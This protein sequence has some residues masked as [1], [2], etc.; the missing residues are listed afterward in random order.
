ML[1]DNETSLDER[2]KV[3]TPAKL[4]SPD[5]EYPILVRGAA[6]AD[7]AIEHVNGTLTLSPEGRM[8]GAGAVETGDARHKFDFGARETLIRGEKGS[9]KLE[10]N[11]KRGG[12]DVF[13]SELVSDVVFKDIRS[14]LP[15]GKAHADSVTI[16]GIGRWNGKPATF[17]ATATDQGEPG[18]GSDVITIKIFAGGK[19]VSTTSGTLRNGNI[20]SNR[21]PRR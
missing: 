1:A 17:E 14:V 9:L 13:V 8:H 3:S 19:M 4:M 21:L 6:D 11:R 5:G 16:L 15:G 2:P 20:Q 10:I 12:D 18:G 7:Y